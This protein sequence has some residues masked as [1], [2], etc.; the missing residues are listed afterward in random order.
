MSKI[1]SWALAAALLTS[2]AHGQQAPSEAAPS[3]APAMPPAAAAPPVLSTG[4]APDYRIGPGDTLQV[5][6]WRQSELSV[7][8][9]V[10]PDGRISTPLNEDMQAVGK[11]PTALAR[12]IETKLSEFLKKPTVN[13]IVTHPISLYS[14]VSIVGQVKSPGSIPFQEG[15]TVMQAVLAVGG[16]GEFGALKR[17]KVLRKDAGG[18]VKE[19]KIN[20][21]NILQKGD[22]SSNITLQAGDVVVIPESHF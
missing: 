3:A 1:M 12:D 10:R 22:M 20:L 16:P 21:Y 11:T 6:V 13:I 8:V 5:F 18:A 19:I 9:P 2:V 17:A 7:T 4:V 15:L 14:Q